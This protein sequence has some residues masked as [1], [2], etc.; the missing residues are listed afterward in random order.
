VTVLYALVTVL[1][2]GAWLL[3]SQRIAF[4]GAHVRTFWVTAAHLALALVVWVWSGRGPLNGAVFWLPF[5]GGMLWAVSGYCAFRAT[6]Q[7][8][9]ATAPAVWSPLNV[10][11]GLAWGAM[12]FGELRGL[13][14]CRT[15]ALVASTAAVL[16]G[17]VLVLLARRTRVRSRVAG[18]SARGLAMAAVAGLLWGTY[19]IPV[20][21][22]GASVWAASLPLATGMFA[23]STSLLAVARHPLRLDRLAHYPLTLLTG[24]LWGVGN[25]GMLLL[26][27]D[28]GTGRG[29]AIAQLGLV[30][31]ALLGVVVLRDPRPGTR[32]A[33]LT[34][35]GVVV[36]TAGGIGLGLVR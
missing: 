17:I 23:G 16:A 11:V 9:M 25:Y 12:L 1:A 31:N 7:L 20:R 32:E 22:S 26:T 33:H 2:W 29:F 18:A 3:P 5:G 4:R 35:L 36:A 30:V 34:L 14:A 19:F 10:I 28:V 6:T 21:L 13:T 15:A 27:E 24:A 8:G